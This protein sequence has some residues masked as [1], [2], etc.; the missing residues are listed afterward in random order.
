M[1][2]QLADFLRSKREQSAIPEIDWQAKKDTWI[3]SVEKLYELVQQ[4]LR[5]SINSK[6][7]VVR[8]FDV[9][10]T[11]DFIGTYS[12]PALELSV[13]SERVEF[14]PKGVTVFG[15]AGRVDI[16]GECDT[17]TLLRDTANAD[18]E[19]TVVLQRIPQLT[20]LP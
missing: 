15:A 18:S 3:R 14:R 1:G 10:I 20:K 5:D 4:I 13:G 16:R 11:E 12:I 19:W 8:T 2:E 6:D 17:V 9:E 7:V